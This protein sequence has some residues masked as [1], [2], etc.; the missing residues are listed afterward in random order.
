MPK[1]I[2][3]VEFASLLSKTKGDSDDQAT[4]AIL[5]N[6]LGSKKFNEKSEAEVDALVEQIE[7]NRRLLKKVRKEL[8]KYEE[9]GQ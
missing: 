4:T 3:V 5:A 1:K 9:D 6:I 7:A 8:L 2:S